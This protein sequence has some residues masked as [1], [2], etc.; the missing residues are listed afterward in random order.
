[1]SSSSTSDAMRVSD[2]D[3]D[4]VAE[5]L[6]DAVGRGQLTVTEV[7]ERLAAAYGA[8]TRR[9]LVAVVADLPQAAAPSPVAVAVPAAA[10]VA[11]RVDWRPWL[12][13]ALLLVG[14]WAMTSLIA[15]HAL[16]FWPAFPI[17]FWALGLA[18]GGKHHHHHHH[19]HRRHHIAHRS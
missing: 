13:G 8:V 6:R 4:R 3:R 5:M 2:E 11:R 14:I 1:M 18:F 16:F 9:D 10:P 17:G 19:H 12:G 15:G 7:D